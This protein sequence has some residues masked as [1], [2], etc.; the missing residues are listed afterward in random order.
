MVL[1]NPGWKTST[2]TG[3]FDGVGTYKKTRE[4]DFAKIYL[5][6]QKGHRVC[7]INILRKWDPAKKLL[8]LNMDTRQLLLSKFNQSV[9]RNK[10][11]VLDLRHVREVHTLD[12]KLSTIQIEDKWKKN[13]E[14]QNLDPLKIL[15]IAYGTQFTLKEWTLL[16]ESLQQ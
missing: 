6:M 14:I 11:M 4:Q 3:S 7:K 8:T 9:T 2:S 1:H 12:Y 15:I 10:P 16:C 13:R 5:A